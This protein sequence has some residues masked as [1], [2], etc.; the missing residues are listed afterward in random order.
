MSPDR[1]QNGDLESGDPMSH[2]IIYITYFFICI[3]ILKNESSRVKKEKN[4]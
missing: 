3:N 4:D 2:I 1:L